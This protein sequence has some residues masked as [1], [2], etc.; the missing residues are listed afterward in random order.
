MSKE[1]VNY[2]G[3]AIVCSHVASGQYPILFAERSEPDEPTDTG[4]Q[5]LCNSG[6]EEN[7][8][9]ARVWAL[10]EVVMLE[11]TLRDCVRLPPGTQL[12]REHG[13]A[14]WKAQ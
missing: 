6:M 2:S 11:P 10:D 8:S 5:F 12:C 3:S 14:T 1:T 13:S 7:L 9:T 4:W